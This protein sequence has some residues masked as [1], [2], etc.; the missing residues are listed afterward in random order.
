M[1][2]FKHPYSM[3]TARWIRDNWLMEKDPEK[4]MDFLRELSEQFGAESAEILQ[5]ISNDYRVFIRDDQMWPDYNDTSWD[6]IV[7][8][9]GRA[10]TCLITRRT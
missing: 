9:C 6:G 1:A 10:L 2:D 4:Q 5:Y 8:S 7:W 3:E